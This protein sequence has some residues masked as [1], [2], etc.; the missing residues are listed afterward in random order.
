[1][2]PAHLGP[3][4]FFIVVL[5]LVIAYWGFVQGALNRMTL[6]DAHEAA[7]K[8]LGGVNLTKIMERRPAALSAVMLYRLLTATAMAALI[9]V[10]FMRFGFSSWLLAVLSVF[11]SWLV[12]LVV[13]VILPSS[14]GY[15]HPI[16]VLASCSHVLWLGTRFVSLLVTRREPD[17]DE[18]R[19]E[20]QED[21]LAVMV[22]RVS[23]SEA[24]EDDERV[25]LHSL[26]ELSNTYIREVMVPRTDIISIDADVSL[27]KALSLFSR[28]GYSRVP[29]TGESVDDMLGVLYLKDA[30]NR[31]HH[32]NDA[33]G[34]L[35]R[36]VMREAL[37]VPET[38]LV[39]DMLHE[40]QAS[41]IHIALAVDEYGGI[42]GLV[43]IEDLLEELVGEM[44]DE[45]DRAE[46]EIDDLGEG[47]YRVPARLSIDELGELY[48]I[49][50]EEDDVDSVGGLLTKAIGRV[51]IAGAEG[52]LYG[53]H[54]A[55]DR[56]EGRRKRLSTVI[57]EQVPE[58]ADTGESAES[59]DE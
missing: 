22:E 40:M 43:T 49:H 23:E 56:F 3:F 28:S 44:L 29:V 8:R 38:K 13:L 25:L 5:A 33:E 16:N 46:L 32:R 21:Q 37:F 26:F 54:L 42:A 6:S 9:A 11:S 57:V 45:H 58:D 24:V 48:G 10:V 52:E 15:K 47:R 2:P 1:M 20:A 53:I 19:E 4:I 39:D 7:A 36:D 31:V 12:V 35:V 59:T 30:I 55:A 14:I 34:V 17:D 51:P 50:I 41:A 18:E 27:D